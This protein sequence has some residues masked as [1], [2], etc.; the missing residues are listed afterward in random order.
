MSS[1]T[2]CQPSAQ[3]SVIV[4]PRGLWVAKL[5]LRSLSTVLSVLI[6]IVCALS[7]FYTGVSVLVLLLPASCITILWNI[8][9]FFYLFCWSRSDTHPVVRIASDLITWTGWG[10]VAALMSAGFSHGSFSNSYKEFLPVIKGVVVVS[11][12]QS[13][14][15]AALFILA[16]SETHLRYRLKKTM[17]R[18]A[19]KQDEA[20]Q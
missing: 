10:A 19:Q 3:P 8:L 2:G 16:C 9:S 4:A 5:S 15:H 12:F 14:I 18:V 6:V 7:E 17:S 11:V 1:N 20:N 13:F